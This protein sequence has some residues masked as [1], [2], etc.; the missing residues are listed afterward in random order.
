M[1]RS[2]LYECIPLFEISLQKKYIDTYTKDFARLTC[3][4]LVK[5]INGLIN[6]IPKDKK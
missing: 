1:A 3:V 4:E 5:I 6:A 2:S